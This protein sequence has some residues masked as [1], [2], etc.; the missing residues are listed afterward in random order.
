[1]LE[2]DF[3]KQVI[4]FLKEHNIYYIKVWGRRLPTFRHT[5]FNIVSKRKIHSNRAKGRNTVNHQRYNFI[6]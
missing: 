5:R 6:I 1:M 3:Q 2:R 4:K